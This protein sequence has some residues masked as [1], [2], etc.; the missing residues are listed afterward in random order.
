MLRIIVEKSAHITVLHCQGRI[1]SGIE[2]RS[3]RKAVMSQGL[4]KTLVLDLGDVSVIDAR[5][6]GVLLELREWTRQK[7]IE[8][9]LINVKRLVRKVFEITQLDAVFD[10]SPRS[11]T[12][13][14]AKDRPKS[15]E[16][17]A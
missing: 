2:T 13:A 10:M 15:A 8:F 1:V 14:H 12:A 16:A 11:G 4:V 9:K 3:L 5:G 7:N 6:L 17:K